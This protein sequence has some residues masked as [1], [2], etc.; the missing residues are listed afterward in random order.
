M[1]PT[2]EQVK[3]RAAF[4]LGDIAQRKFVDAKITPAFEMAYE[5]LVSEM[6]KHQLP[7]RER[8]VVHP[9]IAG[10]TTLTPATAGIS[11]FGELIRLRERPYGT[12]EEFV[13]VDPVDWLR[14]RTSQDRLAE[15]VWRGDTFYFTASSRA[16]DLEIAYSDSG[17]PPV[18]GTVGIDGSLNVLAALTASYAADPEGMWEVSAKQ[19]KTA[20]GNDG[21]G[22]FMHTLLKAQVRA[23]QSRPLQRGAFTTKGRM[24]L[25]M[26]AWGAGP[27]EGG[28]GLGVPINA[29]IT[30]TIDGAND[31]FTL[32]AAP[33]RLHL[34]LNGVLLNE[35]LGYSIAGATI[36]MNPGYIPAV[37]DTLRAE[38][39]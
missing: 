2:V 10:T 16:I 27:A 17:S 23:L 35:S 26:G 28:G 6:V 25:P 9:L 18:S 34:Y 14:Q 31:T 22:G 12:S 20:V 3:A 30:G 38:T 4:L 21:T 29:V 8:V 19:M 24:R 1:I 11:N 13:D 37:G 39:W 33:L 5:E 36:T 32:P 15:F 7:Q